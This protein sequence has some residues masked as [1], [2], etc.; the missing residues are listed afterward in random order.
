[1]V[2]VI[3]EVPVPEEVAVASLLNVCV[4]LFFVAVMDAVELLLDSRLRVKLTDGADF[5]ID[6]GVVLLELSEGVL[7]CCEGL[8]VLDVSK[9]AERD[10]REIVGLV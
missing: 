5:V 9:V 3:V 8:V 6:F 7:A 4:S 1:M 10:C 2:C